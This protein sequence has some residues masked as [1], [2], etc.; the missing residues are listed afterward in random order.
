MRRDT[1]VDFFRDLSNARGPF[2]VHDDGYR[3]RE[4]SYGEVAQAAQAFAARLDDAGLRK[5]DKLVFWAENR[6]EWVAAF[7]GCILTG[8]VVVPI[9]YR[10]SIDFVRRVSAIVAARVVLVGN[11]V[12]SPRPGERPV[13]GAAVWP[14]SELDWRDARPAPEVALSRDDI[15]Q[16]MFTSGATA[17][18]KGVLITH[19]NILANIVPIEGE[20]LKYRRWGRPFFP[21]R[22]LNLL[23]LSHMFGQAMATFIPPML[24]G[25]VVFMR[26]YNPAEIL[27]QVK[28]RRVSVVVSVPKILDVLRDHVARTIPGASTPLVR[29]EPVAFRWWRYRAVHRAFGAKFWSFV[30]GAAPL[31]PALEEFWSRL[32]FLVIQGY[33]LTEA[34]PIVSLNHPF[35]ARKGSVGRAIGGVEVRIAAD[36]EI[37]VRGENVT[38]G[39]FGA[40]RE[41]SAAFEDG[42]LHTGDIGD[43]DPGGQLFVRGRKKEL[44]VTPEGLNVFPE[45]VE[46]VL[47]QQAGV[48]DAAVVGR[49]TGSEERVHAVLLLDV[50]GDPEAVVRS[51]NARLADH[52]RIRGAS[53][54]PGGELPRTE[55]TR[56]LKRLEIRDW[57]DSGRPAVTP[58]GTGGS[59]EALIAR[60]RAGGEIRPE[61]TI[62]ELGLSSLERVELMVAIEEQFHATLDESRFA[63]ARSLG[64]LQELVSQSTA[65]AAVARHDWQMPAWNRRPVVRGIRRASQALW[66]LPLTRLFARVRVEGLEHLG[67][68]DGPVVFAA[69]HQSHLDT[70]VILS[71]LPGSWRRRIAVAMAKE[72]FQA[73][74]HPEGH[75][76]RQRVTSSA[77]YALASFFFNAFPLPQREAGARRTLRYIGDLMSEGSSLLIFPEG[78]RTETGAIGS[79]RPG[80]GMIASR[81]DVWV[82]PVRLDGVD[83]VLHKS[84][85]MARPGAVRVAFG[86]PLQ[87]KGEDYAGLAARV[88]AE[89]RALGA[90]R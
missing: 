9:D 56:K 4:Y 30:V 52:Q 54:W 16:I 39:Y 87:L 71:A 10:S 50:S 90:G 88:E 24:P 59:L 61:T 62:E 20:I 6:P 75:R 38:Q 29:P 65:A 78:E 21:L 79:F 51:A 8:V 23:P 31:D 49:K 13:D 11:D 77:A 70:P 83:R 22:F 33:G 82:V 3:S 34:A 72:F 32:G 66:L 68:I 37:L 84:W 80:I 63:E 15:A 40:D 27:A 57:V 81:L 41:T 12:E 17:E 42:W 18:P 5:G 1:L 35:A 69:N 2:L 48:R 73:H 45:D 47:N 44:V 7:W 28:R 43:I 19:R 25:T 53:V 64:D 58:R 89:V 36:G 67:K 85:K 26:G 86:A 14:M 55:G 74:F 76:W 46:R 60:Y